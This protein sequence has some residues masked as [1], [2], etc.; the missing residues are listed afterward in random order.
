MQEFL[1]KEERAWSRFKCDYFTD[2]YDS[3]GNKSACKIIDISGRWLGI[4][5]NAVLRKAGKASIADPRTKAVVVRAAK[6]RA[7]LRVCN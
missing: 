5:S 7:G 4:I 2:C 1:S 6:G 3:R